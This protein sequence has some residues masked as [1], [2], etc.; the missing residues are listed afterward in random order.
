MSVAHITAREYSQGSHL[1]PSGSPG[2]VQD[3]PHPSVA[4][5]L[6][7]AGPTSHWLQQSRTGL[8][9]SPRQHNALEAEMWVRWPG[10]VNV[11]TLPLVCHGVVQVQR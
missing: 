10:G 1:E 3:R 2:P 8:C 7:T 11:K 6:W 5:M 9:N 4:L